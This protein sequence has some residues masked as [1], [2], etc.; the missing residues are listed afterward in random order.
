MNAKQI[1]RLFALVL[2]CA[3][4]TSGCRSPSWGVGE[5]EDRRERWREYQAWNDREQEHKGPNVRPTMPSDINELRVQNDAAF[6]TT[7]P[8]ARPSAPR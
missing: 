6:R 3:A 1:R 5:Q 2:V 8:G 7:N 4:M